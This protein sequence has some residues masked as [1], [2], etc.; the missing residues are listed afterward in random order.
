VKRP[1]SAG[2]AHPLHTHLIASAGCR[3]CKGPLLPKDRET[4]LVW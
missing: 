3:L 1:G 2:L 4:L